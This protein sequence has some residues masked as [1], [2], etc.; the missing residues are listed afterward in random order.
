MK[1]QK[2][3]FVGAAAA[4]L[5]GTTKADDTINI[6]GSSAFRAAIVKS[7]VSSYTSVTAAY[8]G[9]SITGGNQQ[10]FKGTYPGIAGTTYVRTAWNGS[11][12]GV[13]ALNAPGTYPASYIPTTATT[14]A[15]TT[16]GSAGAYT[17]TGGTLFAGSLVTATPH[18]A[19]SDVYQ[20]STPVTNTTYND[21]QVGV[22]LFKW[23]ATKGA[24]AA[25]SNVSTQLG[26]ALWTNGNLPLSLFTGNSTDSTKTVYATGRY[27]GSGTRGTGLAELG[28]GVFNTVHQYYL[29]MSG[30]A[31][32]ISA[33]TTWPATPTA[34]PTGGTNDAT[35]GNGGYT[36]G[37][38]VR[39]A[40]DGTLASSV[41]VD[42][43]T[44]TGSN[45]AVVAWLG[46]T[47]AATSLTNGAIELKYNGVTYSQT[48][49]QQGQYTLW[50][51]EH[52][53]Y[54]TLST[55]QASVKNDIATNIPAAFTFYGAAASPGL[56]AST[57][58]VYR[59]SD[60]GLVGP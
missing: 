18:F 55:N 34:N 27:N 9:S 46:V 52:A 41:N 32:T 49:V 45:I 30:A 43:S 25:I 33:L 21:D 12:E 20:A 7:V 14:S 23:L 1:L 15:V 56:D 53:L 22:C 47:D 24:G 38:G 19:Y 39:D 8:T 48:A 6:T 29:T 44:V 31:G 37:S 16:G 57:M 2:L 10:L 5:A 4:M 26:N 13:L 35:A 3:L 50:G 54:G 59:F 42:G 60:G 11:V 40:I 28:Y 17:L 36:S 51:Y 58:T